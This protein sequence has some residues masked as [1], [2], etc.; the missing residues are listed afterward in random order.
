MRPPPWTRFFVLA[1]GGLSCS[2]TNA[3]FTTRFASD[4]T[5]ERHTVSVFGVFKDG[6]MSTES[7]DDLGA[8][9]SA[10][11][12]T[13]ACDAAYRGDLLATNPAL[14]SAIDDC[15]RANGVGDELIDA[16]APA[17]TGDLI[18]VFS[19]A[20]R[21]YGREVDGGTTLL[22]PTP[23]NPSVRGYRG[24]GPT[25]G[26]AMH[27]YGR[28]MNAL[29]ISASLFSVRLHRSIALVAMQYYGESFDDAL[30]RLTE[31]LNTVVPGSTC[32]GWNWNVGIDDHRVRALVEP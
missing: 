24:Q 30:K 21:L 11:F 6:R 13:G 18:V 19:V 20:G 22:A 3:Q 10:A 9:L 16:L 29:E 28:N 14:S 8:R 31:K 17:A 4:F 15:V 23:P 26:A 12:A 5:P 27:T 1:L 7:W 25:T 2:D 32:G